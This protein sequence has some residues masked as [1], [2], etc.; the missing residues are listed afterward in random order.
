MQTVRPIGCR[1]RRCEIP[2]SHRS[3]TGLAMSRY[4]FTHVRYRTAAVM[5]VRDDSHVQHYSDWRHKHNRALRDCG[6]YV[7]N[8]VS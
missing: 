4:Q 3:G 2:A 8:M 7:R 5:G 1:W 6:L